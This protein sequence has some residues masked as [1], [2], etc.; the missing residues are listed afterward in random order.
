MVDAITGFVLK[1]IGGYLINE[2]S[3]LIGVKDD[4]EE[5]KTELTCIHGYLKDVE[6]RE[7]EEEVSKEWTKLVLDIAYDIEDVLDTYFLKVEERSQRRGLSR[8]TNKIG[9]TKDAYSIGCDIRNLKRRILDI[10]RKRETYGIG[11]FKEPQGGGNISSLRVR[12]LGRARSVDHEELVIGLEDDAKILLVKLLGDNKE[13]KRHIISIFGMGGLGKTA[14]A[15]KLY[16]SGDVKRRFDCRAWTYVSQ[17]YKTGDI[18]MRIIRSLGMTSGEEL[19][20]I[21]K[22]AEEELEV[23]LHGLLE[24]KKYLVVVDDIWE[25]EA[26]ESLKRALP[27]NHGG[28]RVIITTRIRALAEG[29]DGTVYAHKLRFLT[30]EESWT[31]FEQKA[32][33]NI[34]KIDEDLRRTGKEMVQ[35][36][37]GLPLAIVVLSGILS[38][39]R[40]NEW[41]EVC[42]SLWRRLKDDSIH[43][44]TVFDLS[45]KDLRHESK[46]CFLYLS[47]FPE[48]HEIDIEKLIHLLVAEGFIQEDEEILMEDM[49]RDYIDELIDRSLV[50]AERIERGKVMSCK[51]HDL[52][53]D[54]IIKKAKELNFVN[55]YNEKHHSSAICR[56]EVFHLINNSFPYDRSV[57]KRMR[58]F[59]IIG[60]GGG[61]VKTTNLKLKLL[62]V[63]D[64]GRLSFDSEFYTHTTLPDVIGDLIHLRYLG[65]GDIYVSILPASIS[66]LRSL[67][68][69]NASGHKL[70]QYTTD[71]SNIT[72]LRHVIGKFV[73]E[74]LI[75]D[76]VNLQTLRSISSYSWS[77]L[78]HELLIN[79][80]DLEI[81]DDSNWVDQ[82]TVSLDLVSFSKLKNLR[83]LKL[84]MRNFKLSSKSKTTIGLVDVD[85]P[86]LE[87][88]TLVGITF[89]EDLMS[90]LQILPR[91]ED[92]VLKDC[93]YPGAKIISISAQGFGRLRNLELFMEILDELRIEEE[94]MP[95]LIKLILMIP[96]RLRAFV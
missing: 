89:E 28:S 5:L 34:E 24:G 37:G 41:H 18:L 93:S 92:L 62:R 52:L 56:R 61:I 53:R 42:A 32:F 45:F 55:I 43:V 82:R 29:V 30:F 79:L 50:K 67:Q 95:S 35:K 68:T 40:T 72:T 70:F 25:Q 96:D 1:K 4:L 2:V 39:K 78:N 23:Y 11:G 84:E 33:R 17:E 86:S 88:L 36:C 10:T 54:V 7:R 26:W 77:K 91:L 69:L 90:A 27:Y 20:K 64:I 46:L 66:N 85:F 81:Y 47:I 8:M 38:R 57:N 48:D 74:C 12:Q 6:A 3:M 83:V 44:S 9:K 71:L 60:E 13:D 73:G 49:A 63:L 80:R 87:S 21:R 22:F 59:L 15:R 58:S 76:G 16:N 51:I 65:I 14:L 19:E 94:A 75:G 31:L